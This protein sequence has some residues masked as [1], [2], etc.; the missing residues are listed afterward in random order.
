MIKEM[1]FD[2]PIGTLS[3]CFIILVIALIPVAIYGSIQDQKQWEAFK[4]EQNCEITQKMA[5]HASVGMMPIIGGQGG[6]GMVTTVTP[7]KT[8]WT[9][10]DG[11]TYWR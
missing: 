6:M 7:D 9:C 2:W 10:D 5:G 8:A 3:V 1:L 4:I 11:I